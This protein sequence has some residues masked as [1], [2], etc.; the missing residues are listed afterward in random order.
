MET[1]EKQVKNL[2]KKNYTIYNSTF[3]DIIHVYE[4][5][6][7]SWLLT[8]NMYVPAVKTMSMP[9]FQIL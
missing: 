9:L 4:I 3:Q 1:V 8:L 5:N 7:G 2:S 6:L